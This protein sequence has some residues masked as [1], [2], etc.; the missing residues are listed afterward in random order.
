RIQCHINGPELQSFCQV[1]GAAQR[2]VGDDLD[3]HITVCSFPHQVCQ[4][5]G[6]LVK[7][8]FFIIRMSQL[9]GSLLL[10]RFLTVGPSCRRFVAAATTATA[11]N[12]HQQCCHQN[13]H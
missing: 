2:T 5:N 8:L 6:S 13:S 10:C 9:E 12:S 7:L 1:P 3:L 11:H 4:Q